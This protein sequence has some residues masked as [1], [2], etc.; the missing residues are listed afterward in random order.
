[1]V[2]IRHIDR[3]IDPNSPALTPLEKEFR[4]GLPKNPTPAQLRRSVEA[5]VLRKIPYDWDWNTWGVVDYTPTIEE[6]LAKGREDCDGR[7]ILAA[8][9]LRRLGQDAQLVSSMRHMWVAVGKNELMGPDK[10]KLT[11]HTAQ[12]PKMNWMALKYLPRDLTFGLAV[13]PLVR[14]IIVAFAVLGLWSH[15]QMRRRWIV[16]PGLMF[17]Y[18]LLFCQA[19]YFVGAN[20][21]QL[22]VSWVGSVHLV[23]GLACLG[24]TSLAARRA[25]P[26]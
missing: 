10:A 26:A 2:R 12:G 18:G 14:E 7:A 9:L 23:V 25:Y 11:I 19:A 24:W 5:F 22:W 13:F 4:A 16:V 3:L 20:A 15:P 21:E 8:S 1:M 17:V 6:L